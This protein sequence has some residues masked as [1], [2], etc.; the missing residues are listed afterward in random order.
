MNKHFSSFSSS[1]L[2]CPLPTTLDGRPLIISIITVPYSEIIRLYILW[3]DRS[4]RN[5]HLDGVLLHHQ[6]S[7]VIWQHLKLDA[8][9]ANGGPGLGAGDEVG[10]SYVDTQPHVY[11]PLQLGRPA[12]NHRRI[13][14]SQ[15]LVDSVHHIG[16]LV[17][18]GLRW[19]DSYN[20]PQPK[21][22]V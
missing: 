16:Q 12:A 9:R 13:H 4:Q 17:C 21:T 19:Y 10:S 5:R 14:H 3:Q 7:V 18:F 22:Q 15:T 20:S 8:L 11:D 1:Y 2:T 6:S